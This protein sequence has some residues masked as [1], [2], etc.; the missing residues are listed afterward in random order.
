MNTEADPSRRAAELRARL[1]RAA[2][3]YYT[4]DAPELPDA[5]YDRLFQQLQAIEA[6]H[7]ELRTPDSPTQRVGGA[8]LDSLASV[9]HAVPMLSIRTETDT[10]A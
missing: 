1:Q 6:A 3:Q 8:I 4:L 9:R 2:H 10:T 7:P 5:E